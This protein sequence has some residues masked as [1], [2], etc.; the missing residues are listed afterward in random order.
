MLT[1]LNFAMIATASSVKGPEVL[2]KCRNGWT[3]SQVNRGAIVVAEAVAATATSV[4]SL[5]ILAR[6]ACN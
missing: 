6:F 5:V 3:V 1:M 4:S 2:A